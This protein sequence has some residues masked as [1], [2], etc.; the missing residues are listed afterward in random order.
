MDFLSS[1]QVQIALQLILSAFLGGLIGLERESK[2]RAAGLRTN[3]LVCLGATLFTL[4]SFNG[5]YWWLGKTGVAFD[6]SRIIS[7]IVMG[8]GFIGAGLI[9]YRQ[10]RVEGLT[11]AAG[12]WVVAGI[13]IA[14]GAKLYFTAIFATFLVLAILN[15][16]RILEEKAFAKE[17]ENFLNEED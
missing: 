3:S 12:I 13:G 2:Q 5:F 4:I 10:F 8:V 1:P 6:P 14:I 16:L 11:T 15:G 9:I 17:E 7:T